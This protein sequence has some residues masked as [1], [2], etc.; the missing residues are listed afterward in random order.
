MIKCFKGIGYLLMEYLFIFV[1]K[2][3]P[4]AKKQKPLRTL[5]KEPAL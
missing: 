4:E 1:L 5:S 2:L 3:K